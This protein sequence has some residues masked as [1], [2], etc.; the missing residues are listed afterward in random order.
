MRIN[1][2]AVPRRPGIASGFTIIEVL[3][4]MMMAGVMFTA[5]Y[6]GIS[7]GF[8]VIK[9]ARENTRATQIMVEK[10]ETIR[11]YSWDQINSNGFIPSNF[12]ASYYPMGVVGDRGTLYTGIV[13]VAD[14]SLG[15]SYAPEVKKVTVQLKWNTGNLPRSRSISTYVSRYGLQ[16]YIYY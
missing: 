2:S 15:T 10:M 4:T 12:V 11:L 3:F 9:L 8:A 1:L 7:S 6:A 14:S 16:N 5:L 13:S